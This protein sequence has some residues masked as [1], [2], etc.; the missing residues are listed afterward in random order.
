MMK[1]VR[2]GDE[3]WLDFIVKDDVKDWMGASAGEEGEE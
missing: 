1:P 2:S 3:V